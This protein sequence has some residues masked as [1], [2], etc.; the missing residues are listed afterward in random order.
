MAEFRNGAPETPAILVEHDLTFSLFQQ[1]ADNDG[2]EESRR[3]HARWL[4]Y[5]RR[6]LRDYDT[7]WTVSEEDRLSAI[8]EGASAGR[9]FAIPNG[10][11]VFRFRPSAAP[12]ALEI[13]FVGSFRHLPNAL[14]FEQLRSEIMPRVWSEFPDAVARVVAGPDHEW[15]WR[16]LAGK[17]PL[18]CDPRIEIHGFVEDLRPLY[19]RAAVVA[20]PLDVSAGTNIKILEAMAC[21][22]AIVVTPVGCAGLGLRDGGE[23]LIRSDWAGF[24]GAVCDILSDARLRD[25]LGRRARR[26]AE[27]RF[28]WSAIQDAAYGSYLETI[29]RQEGSRARSVVAGD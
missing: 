19:A 3:E 10:V 14:A 20:A 16:R 27:R 1:L 13:L 22:K 4:Q 18:G 23:A 25:G 9:T 2:G 11:D 26:A 5:E 7:V 24:G 17:R 28:S 8:R 6:W 21:G 29:E 12:P 15:F